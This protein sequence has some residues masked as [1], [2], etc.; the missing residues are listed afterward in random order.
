LIHFYWVFFKIFFKLICSEYCV[1]TN[2]NFSP[3]ENLIEVEE[4]R[5]HNVEVEE[6]EEGE[7]ESEG[8]SEREDSARLS[9]Q[10]YRLGEIVTF[11]FSHFDKYGLPVRPKLQRKR[12]DVTWPEV[13]ENFRLGLPV[14]KSLP[15]TLLPLSLSPTL[16]I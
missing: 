9:L 14:K 2:L 4:Q 3:D 5:E 15:G 1:Y 13:V 10:Q 7:E 12:T 11:T 6:I 16:T 8:G